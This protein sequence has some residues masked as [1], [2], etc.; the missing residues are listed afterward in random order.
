MLQREL[1][2][3]NGARRNRKRRGRG[4]GSGHGSY[5]GR[6]VKGQNSRSGG[7]VRPNFE[8]GQ[9][10]ITKSLPHQRGFTNI[11]RVEYNGVN[12]D[13]LASFQEDS[14]V[15][16]KVLLET[17][18]VRNL[19]RPVKILGRGEVTVALAVTAHK[20]TGSARAKIE[21]AGGSVKEIG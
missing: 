17:G 15:T 3:P 8:G 11:F 7:G 21:A 1:K 14:K 2:A 9:L 13:K 12:L 10:P 4:D 16:P 18:I 6:G 19:N 20:F 5:S